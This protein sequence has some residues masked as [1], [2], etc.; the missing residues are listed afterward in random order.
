MGE[1]FNSEGEV[2]RYLL[3]RVSDEAALEE[4]EE[5]LF[6]DEE[7]CTRV[8]LAED[9]LVNDY[10]LGLLSEEDAADFAATLGSNPERRFKLE[11]TRAL[12]EKALASRAG[13][14]SKAHEANASEAS[15]LKGAQT[16]K[17]A[18]VL[19]QTGVSADDADSSFLSPLV[20]LVRRPAYA[21]AFALLLVALIAG[22][23]YFF[24]GGERVDEL[25]ELR[26]LYSRERPTETRVYGFGYAPLTQLRGEPDAQDKSRLRLI[27]NNF[28]EAAQKRPGAPETHHALGVF[29]LTQR[30]YADAISELEAASKLDERNAR[31][32]NDLGAAFFEMAKTSPKEKRLETLGRALEEFTRAAELDANS[33]EALF[34]KAL[35]QQELGQPR[36]AR[37]TWTL[38]LQ[39]DSSSPWAEEA[40]KNL[41]R[42]DDASARFKSGEKALEERVLRDFLE[43]F[44]QRDDAR[45]Q[46]IHDEAK[47]LLRSPAVAQQLSR[48]YIAARLGG[49]E[50]AAKESLDALAFV[51]DYELAR[52]S[53]F[54]F[55][56]S[57]TSTRE[58]TQTSSDGSRAPQNSSTRGSASCSTTGRTS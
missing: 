35:T 17:A 8:A 53:E 56:N 50:A 20:A 1:S 43:A 51:G 52:H 23:V 45:A 7:F 34:N 21:G 5:L 13:D 15:D 27:E 4:L 9:E 40:R 55:L 36:Q 2:R 32:H 42:L 49:D 57:Q 26:A 39:K 22:S 58:R 46:R 25:A 41:A 11:L 10:V 33:T 37:E 29:N 38:Y 44:R 48:R 16:L 54:F 18:D 30:K 14:S 31:I 3:G 24:R 12:R 19:A 6:T 47:G 28:I